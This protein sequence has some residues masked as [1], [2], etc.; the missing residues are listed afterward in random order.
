MK[1]SVGKILTATATLA[2]AAYLGFQIYS[3]AKPSLQIESVGLY[4]AYDD[5]TAT[6]YL[7]RQE[8]LV[9]KKGD[10]V[11]NLIVDEGER[12]SKDGL[13]AK[14]YQNA[15]QAEAGEQI[16][17]I[18]N[19]LARLA[20]SSIDQA[21]GADEVSA[22]EEKI[23]GTIR[24][25]GAYG[26]F[27]NGTSMLSAREELTILMNQ[28]SVLLGESDGYDNIINELK[29][30]R[31]ALVAKN[32]G[33]YYESRSP[34][35]GYFVSVVDGYE[36][37]LTTQNASK[38]TVTDMESLG[39]IR[40]SDVEKDKL[41]GKVVTGYEWY[42]ATVLPEKEL[43]GISPGK[44]LNIKFTFSTG[45]TLPVTVESI[46]PAENGKQVLVLRC[47]YDRPELH[48]VRT[49][50]VQIIR[51]EYEGLK[52]S[53]RS[54]HVNEQ[55]QPGV[56]VRT[57]SI[58]QW[59][60]VTVKFTKDNYHLLVYDKADNKGLQ[61]YDEVIVGGKDLYNGKVLKS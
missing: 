14:V 45:E 36:K 32:G 18:D 41:F 4:T 48:T 37:I 44:S 16:A 19:R 56:Y 26:D 30:E 8:E 47:N 28:K 1:T 61:L 31:A 22:M 29:E 60:P 39:K 50:T 9:P 10:G 52:V 3:F 24:Q 53:N 7:I 46:S 58:M 21:L 38:L 33:G 51:R 34:Y 49:Q 27:G 17:Q 59:R 12:V 25:L 23:T 54:L 11:F 57:G 35:S 43:E 6:G 13:I 42:F 15:E 5:L 55:G 40:P 2:V 20:E